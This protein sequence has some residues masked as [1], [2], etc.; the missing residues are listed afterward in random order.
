MHRSFPHRNHPRPI[1][2]RNRSRCR[3]SRYSEYTVHSHR[4][5]AKPHRSRFRIRTHPNDRRSRSRDHTGSS[6]EYSDLIC[7]GIR[8][9]RTLVLKREIHSFSHRP[10]QLELIH[11]SSTYLYN[12]ALHRCCPSN[13][14]LHRRSSSS[15]CTAGCC[16]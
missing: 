10:P 16:R 4:Q 6:E 2:R 7:T 11:H 9:F 13:H 8:S 14:R 1:H 3:T 15:E 5:T 12:S